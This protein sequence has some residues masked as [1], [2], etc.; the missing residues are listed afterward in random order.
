MKPPPAAGDKAIQ[1]YPIHR[2]ADQETPTNRFDQRT[3]LADGLHQNAVLYEEDPSKSDGPTI[4]GLGD[5]AHRVDQDRWQ[6]R[7]GRRASGCRYSIAQAADDVVAQT[8]SRSIFAGKP[9]R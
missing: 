3:L 4:F 7:R 5:L 2:G 6:T 1:T 9:H 8:Q